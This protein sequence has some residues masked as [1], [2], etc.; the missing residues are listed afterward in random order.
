[1]G[2]WGPPTGGLVTWEAGV[3]AEGTWAALGMG[4]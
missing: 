2:G 1:M 3:E 4:F